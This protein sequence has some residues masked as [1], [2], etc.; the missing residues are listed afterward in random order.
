MNR[1]WGRPYVK[2]ESCRIMGAEIYR[3]PISSRTEFLF[4]RLLASRDAEGWGEATFNWLNDQVVVALRILA[5]EMQGMTVDE[6]RAY[7]VRQPGWKHGLAFQ[8]A[9]S[10]LE[11]ALLDVE[12]RLRDIPFGCM[13][14]PRVH[15]QVACYANIN[16]GTVDRS[17]EGWARRATHA[18]SAGFPA[19]KLAPFDGVRCTATEDHVASFQDG[20]DVV[21]AV[22]KDVG[23][24]VDLM[25]DCHWRFK[26]ESALALVRALAD[27][28]PAWIEGPVFEDFLAIDDLC[29][30]R[31]VANRSEIRLAGGEYLDGPRAFAPF[32]DE[33]ALDI[34]NPDIRICGVAGT[35]DVA[36]Q[37]GARG[38]ELAPHNHLGPVMA[39]ASLHLM[40]VVPAALTLELQ[41]EEGDVA[42]C[43]VDPD[44]LLPEQGRLVVPSDPGLGIEI[45]TSCLIP[46]RP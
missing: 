21:A 17:P 11:Q 46:V 8:I 42:S 1:Q 23:P 4:V 15:E 3:Q 14:G 44:V 45:D 12:S 39:V 36:I 37:A 34:V 26:T 13:F 29:R 32:L 35:V 28:S 20:I 5:K 6:G 38:L 33:G 10:A 30:I 2:M 31:E 43:L 24:D 22:R 9:M 19:L 18:I 41:F 7:L 16:R 27:L 25:V 40:S